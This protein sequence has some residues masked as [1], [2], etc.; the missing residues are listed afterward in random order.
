MP[1]TYHPL[2]K[3]TEYGCVKCQT[4]HT[5]LDPLFDLHLFWQAKHHYR[6]RTATPAE[7]LELY[8]RQEEPPRA[9]RD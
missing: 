6:Q 7:A 9:D 4:W 8:L 2:P 1:T 3:I 5:A